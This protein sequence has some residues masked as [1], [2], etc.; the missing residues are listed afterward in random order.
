[1]AVLWERI[2]VELS[3]LDAKPTQQAIADRLGVSRARVQRAIAA[4]REAWEQ[5]SADPG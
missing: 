3:R 2:V 5:L 4:N 1:M